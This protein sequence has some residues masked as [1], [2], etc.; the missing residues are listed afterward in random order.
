M[1]FFLTAAYADPRV[2]SETLTPEPQLQHPGQRFYSP[3]TG[4]WLSRDPIGEA[5]G[6]NRYFYVANDPVNLLDPLGREILSVEVVG[7]GQSK[8]T[9]EQWASSGAKQFKELITTGTLGY[10]GGNATEPIIEDMGPG[11]RHVV[12]ERKLAIG[13]VQFEYRIKLKCPSI[14]RI[15]VIGSPGKFKNFSVA[16][17]VTWGESS[18]RNRET[19]QFVKRDPLTIGRDGPSF[20]VGDEAANIYDRD[21]VGGRQV[22][23]YAGDYP[24]IFEPAAKGLDYFF[25]GNWRFRVEDN[26]NAWEGTFKVVFQFADSNPSGGKGIFRIMTQPHEVKR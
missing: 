18:V 8:I 3:G 21:Y 12:G 10:H 23:V 24:R 14:D 1:G 11:N 4:R 25:T 19:G 15:D 26:D 9:P 5:G 2:P 6:D 17:Y 13:L 16:Q 7:D 22:T 20:V